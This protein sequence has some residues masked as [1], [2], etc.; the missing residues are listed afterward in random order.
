MKNSHSAI[1]Y[2]RII[3]RGVILWSVH[4]DSTYLNKLFKS[5]FSYLA[6]YT[7]CS[8]QY[9]LLQFLLY[10]FIFYS[11][12]R[13]K[14]RTN[15]PGSPYSRCNKMLNDIIA[16]FYYALLAHFYWILNN[17]KLIFEIRSWGKSLT[18]Y[19]D[20]FV[21]FFTRPS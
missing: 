10:S 3:Y 11:V 7:H 15:F 12:L 8:V 20:I 13:D 19:L 6:K 14:P 17:S 9:I 16:C 21:T 5:M 18:Q 4:I 1:K 2:K